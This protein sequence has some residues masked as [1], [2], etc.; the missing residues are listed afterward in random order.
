MTI[1]FNQEALYQYA[2]NA[3]LSM[4]AAEKRLTKEAAK[5]DAAIKKMFEK[6]AKTQGN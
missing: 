6:R 4:A 2:A 3:G 5:R 1:K